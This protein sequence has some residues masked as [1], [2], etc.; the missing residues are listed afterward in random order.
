MKSEEPLKFYE[1]EA[2]DYDIRRWLTPAGRLVNAVQM[3]IFGSLVGELTNLRILEIAAGTGRFT[4]VLLENG[5]SVIAFDISSSMLEQLKQN[6]KDH[7]NYGRLQIIVGDAR[8]MELESCSVDV[9]VCFNALSHIPEHKRVLTEVYRVLKP[10]GFFLFNFP[11]YL[12]LYLLFGLY[13]NL[14]KKSITRNVYTRWYSLK[15]FSRDLMSSGFKIENIKGQLH[16]PTWTPSFIV[17]F[18][19]LI[20]NKLRNGI[21]TKFAPI[22]FIKAKK[23]L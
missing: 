6:L 1:K 4:K 12:S 13:V 11:N 19:S 22:L 3:E 18:M 23:D 14:R 8:T 10:G 7:P 2:K 17:P 21:G 9:V 5:N 20:D 15:E 16:L